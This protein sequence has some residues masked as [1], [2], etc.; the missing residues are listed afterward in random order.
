MTK[1]FMT[2]RSLGPSGLCRSAL[3]KETP[4]PGENQGPQGLGCLGGITFFLVFLPTKTL[5]K[6]SGTRAALSLGLRE[7][8]MSVV[9]SW[10]GNPI[11]RNAGLW[12]C[13]VMQLGRASASAAGRPASFLLFFSLLQSIIVL[14]V[15]FLKAT[16]GLFTHFRNLIVLSN[17]Q[18]ISTLKFW[19]VHCEEKLKKITVSKKFWISASFLG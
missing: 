5:K 11:I 19:S 7:K 9:S 3:D 18:K 4:I 17:D 6:Y 2:L 1:K 16:L 13:I 12:K 10:L 14:C 15:F 8:K